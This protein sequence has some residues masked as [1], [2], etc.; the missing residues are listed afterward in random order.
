M[1]LRRPRLVFGGLRRKP[2]LVS[3]TDRSTRRVPP[4]R[5]TSPHWSPSSSPRL[6]PVAS[7]SATM[8]KS[9]WPSKSARDLI[10]AQNLDLCFL[11]LRR[12]MDGR[13]V[14]RNRPVLGGALQHQAQYPVS[15][16]DRASRQAASQ[17]RAMPL[18]HMFRL[19]PL[20]LG[21]TQMRNDLPLC[22]FAVSLQRLGRQAE[23]AVEPSPQIF[24]EC[25][26]GRVGEG[27]PVGGC[28]EPG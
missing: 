3:S 14:P 27:A 23:S 15:V 16:P 17:Q 24:S 21:R 9:V 28:E 4:S 19:E 18:L 26:A 13:H 7:A 12:C 10:G 22:K 25:R 5:S 8:G 11:D 20:Q 1:I 2:A 6:M